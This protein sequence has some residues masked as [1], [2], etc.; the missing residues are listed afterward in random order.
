MRERA[1]S[2]CFPV[3]MLA[4]KKKQKTTLEALNLKAESHSF[5]NVSIYYGANVPLSYSIVRII[6]LNELTNYYDR[7]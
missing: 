4:S 2:C 1:T 6:I 3:V 7:R 5:N